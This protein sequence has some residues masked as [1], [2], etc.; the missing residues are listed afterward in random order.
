MRW[1]RSSRECF[2][3]VELLRREQSAIIITGAVAQLGE[4]CVRNAE[5]AGSTPVGSTTIPPSDPIRS[6]ETYLSLEVPTPS[7]SR[8]TTEEGLV[9]SVGAVLELGSRG[10]PPRPL[11]D[12]GRS[13]TG[14]RQAGQAP[15]R[16]L[17]RGAKLLG[18]GAAIAILLLAAGNSGQAG[19]SQGQIPL[20]RTLGLYGVTSVVFSPDGRY[21]AVRN[22]WWQQRAADRHEQ[23]AGDPHFRRPHRRCSV[24]GVQPRRAAP[25][26]RLL[27]QDDQA[28]GHQR[29]GG[30]VRSSDQRSAVREGC[31]VMP[32]CLRP[33]CSLKLAC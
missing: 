13:R 3:S 9:K 25:G 21:L 30:E 14:K 1:F 22:S 16:C 18:I 32:V 15:R 27:G 26:I 11:P 28:V 23:V 20:M 31:E 4:R 5:V 8:N 12:A 24:R 29:S 7:R 10:D 6:G 33:S 19:L 17:M 2:N